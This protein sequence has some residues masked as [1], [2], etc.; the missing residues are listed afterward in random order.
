[1]SDPATLG[2]ISAGFVEAAAQGRTVQDVGP[3]RAFFAASPEP[4]LSL[5][6][7]RED[8]DD[9][10]S[11][12][13]SLGAAFAAWDRTPRLEVLAE[14][15]PKLG[16]ALERAGFTRDD[17]APV[18]ALGA[19]DLT[20]VTPDPDYNTDYRPLTAGEELRAVL[21]AQSRAYGGSG[22]GSDWL[23]Q[24]RAGLGAGHI[25]GAALWRNGEPVA[26]ATL[27]LG[28]EVGELA[29]VFTDI[30][31]RR[32]GLAERVCKPLLSTFF[33][34]GGRLAWLSAAP[35]AEGLYRRLGF[36]EVGTQV[37]YSKSLQQSVTVNRSADA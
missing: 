28:G 9:W 36:A 1:M 37:N 5:A 33:A 8:V 3:F 6:L 31:F 19:A 11:S 35:E 12:I 14:L 20:P 23:P 30:L 27:T 17:E 15:F 2:R 10:A 4:F 21:D 25:L 29:G 32:R 7:P 24:L 13:V 34:A 26:G 18:M 16:G 22:D